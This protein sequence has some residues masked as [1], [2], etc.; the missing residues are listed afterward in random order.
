MCTRYRIRNYAW[1][2]L[3]SWL[4]WI[5]SMRF[6]LF[7][8]FFDIVRNKRRAGFISSLTWQLLYLQNVGGGTSIG[9]RFVARS[10]S[11]NSSSSCWKTAVAPRTTQIRA[12]PRVLSRTGSVAYNDYDKSS[13][14]SSFECSLRIDREPGIIGFIPKLRKTTPV[15]LLLRM[16]TPVAHRASNATRINNEKVRAVRARR[17]T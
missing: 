13:F 11:F 1:Q 5:C 2:P 4:G 8:F 17:K 7:I 16:C 15:P 6:C 9:N 3:P 14:T 12:R 10:F